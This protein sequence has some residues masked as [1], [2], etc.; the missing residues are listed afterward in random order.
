MI[1]ASDFG[2]IFMDAMRGSFSDAAQAERGRD[3]QLAQPSDRGEVF[4][5]PEE[6]PDS[7]GETRSVI[8]KYAL[9]SLAMHYWI[10]RENRFPHWVPRG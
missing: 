3:G 6:I 4:N 10:I 7:Q 2:H 5:D 8:L 1:L 9:Y